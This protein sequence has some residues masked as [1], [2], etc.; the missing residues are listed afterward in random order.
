MMQ[1]HVLF[2]GIRCSAFEQMEI[3]NIVAYQ[4]TTAEATGP[5]DADPYHSHRKNIPTAR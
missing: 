2:R 1:L 5:P 3:I 4:E